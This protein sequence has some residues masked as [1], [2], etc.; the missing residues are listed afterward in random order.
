[1]SVI[2]LW[3]ADTAHLRK[4]VIHTSLAYL[5]ACG[6]QFWDM[7]SSSKMSPRAMPGERWR[8][9]NS[10]SSGNDD[11]LEIFENSAFGPIPAGVYASLG[12]RVSYWLKARVFESYLPY[13]SLG[14]MVALANQNSSKSGLGPVSP[15][16]A[17]KRSFGFNP[18]YARGSSHILASSVRARIWGW[19]DCWLAVRFLGM[20][21]SA[22]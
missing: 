6:P 10:S 5:I 22:Y 1:L 7:P 2:G 9:V 15:P 18:S 14:N 4:I 21:F 11:C 3:R 19:L 13:R 12:C 17:L 20:N 8:Y 16:D